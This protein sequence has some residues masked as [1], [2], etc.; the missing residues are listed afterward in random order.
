LYGIIRRPASLAAGQHRG[1]E[2]P[3]GTQRGFASA[4]RRQQGPQK[5]TVRMVRRW[6]W[7]AIVLFLAVLAHRGM[8][9]EVL[10]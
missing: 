5:I 2:D 4:G 7:R 9:H 6:S 1:N 8:A 3:P 10:K